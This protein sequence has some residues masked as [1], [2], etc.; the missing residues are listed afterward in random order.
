VLSSDQGSGRLLLFTARASQILIALAIAGSIVFA[1]VRGT[2]GGW[3]LPMVVIALGCL[4]R[5]EHRLARRP[6]SRRR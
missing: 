5:L 2:V 6:R 1:A 4:E 3:S